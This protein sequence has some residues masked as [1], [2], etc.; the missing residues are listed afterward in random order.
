VAY[1]QAAYEQAQ[2]NEAA[3]QAALASQAQAAPT[4]QPLQQQQPRNMENLTWE[5]LLPHAA[6]TFQQTSKRAGIP[7]PPQP[8]QQQ[9]RLD[10]RGCIGLLA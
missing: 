6:V 5:Q 3:V 10:V 7:S 2:A 8:P 4:R 9:Q 1:Q